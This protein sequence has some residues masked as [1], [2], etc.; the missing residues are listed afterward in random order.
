MNEAMIFGTGYF[1]GMLTCFLVVVVFMTKDKPPKLA[2]GSVED[3]DIAYNFED[4]ICT[5]SKKETEVELHTDA[6]HN[7]LRKYDG[8]IDLNIQVEQAPS[9]WIPHK[10]RKDG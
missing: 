1:L 10:D 5:I 2:E 9:D 3:Y 8:G 7:K 4:Q 6:D